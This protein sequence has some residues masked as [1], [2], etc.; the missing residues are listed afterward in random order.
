MSQ[1]KEQDNPEDQPREVE[2]SNCSEKEFRI[3]IGKTIQSLGQKMEARIKKMQ[4]MFNRDLEE[5]RKCEFSFHP[6]RKAMPKNVQTT[7]Q[8]HSSHTLAK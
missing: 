3:M 5:L 4:E 7:A 1:L 8:L 2:I 6:Q